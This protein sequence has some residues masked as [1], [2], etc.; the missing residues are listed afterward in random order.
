MLSK[1]NKLPHLLT[2]ACKVKANLQEVHID[3]VDQLA[4]ARKQNS[5]LAAEIKAWP[6][7]HIYIYIY[8]RTSA[9]KSLLQ[10]MKLDLWSKTTRSTNIR[11]A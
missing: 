9:S 3:A 11:C 4:Q 1:V 2:R 8:T 5:E 6:A 7:I 10:S